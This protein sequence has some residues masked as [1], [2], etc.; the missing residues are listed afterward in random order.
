[1]LNATQTGMFAGTPI[2]SAIRLADLTSQAAS[3]ISIANQPRPT[4]TP[5]HT[6]LTR[7][8]FSLA[9]GLRRGQMH[10]RDSQKFLSNR[11]F[12]IY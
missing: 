9:S 3:F 1:M 7:T 4:G 6:P 12:K 5:F 8:W 10:C 2:A 11:R